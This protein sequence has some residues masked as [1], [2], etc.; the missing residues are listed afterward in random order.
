MTTLVVALPAIIRGRGGAKKTKRTFPGWISRV[1]GLGLLGMA[2]AT[3]VAYVLQVNRISERGFEVRALE[4]NIRELKENQSSLEADIR[5]LESIANVS[6]RVR[7]L[8][9]VPATDAQFVA[10]D[11]MAVASR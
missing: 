11:A 1:F 2:L 3:A 9:M 10:A 5:A 7:T 6:E 4:Q 8:G